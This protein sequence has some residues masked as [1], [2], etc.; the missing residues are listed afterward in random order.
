MWRRF[1]FS[2]FLL[3]PVVLPAQ[4][5]S[6]FRWPM[7]GR[8]ETTVKVSVQPNDYHM[9][10]G[11]LH[12]VRQFNASGGKLKIE[13]VDVGENPDIVVIGVR[14]TPSKFRKDAFTEVEENPS[15]C[16][17]MGAVVYMPTHRQDGDELSH[18]EWLGTLGH[19]LGH[20]LGL[21]HV[22][23]TYALMSNGN[24]EPVTSLTTVDLSYI[25]RVYP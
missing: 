9:S 12:W 1:L 24:K 22:P 17:L 18:D 25:R 4:Y 20:A 21:G 16:S 5:C 19:E 15:N 3:F 14:V 2:L 8:K 7:T 11:V 23:S 10:L 6:S 13:M